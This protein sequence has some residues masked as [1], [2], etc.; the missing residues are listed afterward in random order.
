MGTHTG[1]AGS[2]S[3]PSRE[4]LAGVNPA[5]PEPQAQVWGQRAR[6]SFPRPGSL[7]PLPTCLF[8]TPTPSPFV[9]GELKI[10][11][12]ARAKNRPEG[13]AAA[14]I[15]S[16]REGHVRCSSPFTKARPVPLPPGHAGQWTAGG[17]KDT[18]YPPGPEN[19]VHI[20]GGRRLERPALWGLW[21]CFVSLPPPH[22]G[23][24]WPTR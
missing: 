23:A 24:L 2:P 8:S 3:V 21:T 17:S 4:G 10:V 19:R 6:G 11:P 14:K 9:L 5:G 16:S 1:L 18:P 12:S 20:S 22:Q 13:E 7:V 15:N